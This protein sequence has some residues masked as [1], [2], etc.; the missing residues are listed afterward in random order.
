MIIFL[1]GLIFLLYFSYLDLKKSEISN[2]SILAFLIISIF[3]LIFGQIIQ[4]IIICLFW[5]L[6]GY[7]FWR[8][9]AL[10]GADIKILSIL[11]IYY[12]NGI[13]NIYAGAFIF[14]CIFLICGLIYGLFS[15]QIIKN[16]EIPFLTIITLTYIISFLFW[17]IK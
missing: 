3:I 4:S 11:P 8:F 15:R 17:T 7:L 1:I 9:K 10:G 2:Y 14:L 6:F 13:P 16:K 5:F 12:L